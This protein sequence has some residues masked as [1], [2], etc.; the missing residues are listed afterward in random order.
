MRILFVGMPDSVHTARWIN[1]VSDLGWDLHLFSASPGIPNTELR[2]INV[3]NISFSRP[4]GLSSSARLRGLW[5]LRIGVERLSLRVSSSTWLTRLIRW[6][7]P[8]VVHSMEMQRAGYLTWEAKRQLK[9]RF[10]PWIVSNWGSDIYLFGRLAAHSE[11]IRAVM[12]ACDYYHCECHRDVQLARDFGFRGEVLPV[13]PVAGGFDLEWMR[14]LRQPGP[15]STRRTIALKGYQTWAGRALIGLRAIELCADALRNYR[16]VVYMPTPEVRIAAEL[17]RES[18]GIP[19]EFEFKSWTRADVLRLHGRARVS[20]GLSIS[21]AISTSLLEAMIMGSFPVQSN[22]A[23][24]DEWLKDGETG[25]LVPP[26]DPEIIAAAIRRALNDDKLVDR[27]SEINTR[28]ADE[29]LDYSIIQ[30]KTIELYQTIAKR[31]PVPS[32]VNWLNDNQAL[33]V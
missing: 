10:P 2:N 20:I 17:V 5:P 18:T 25:I 22:T 3:Y 29:R 27:A 24:A 28:V 1:Q 15:T 13:F 19:F 16:V 8:D 11:K 12:A 26:N 6:L 21:D 14:G 32:S 7:K 4:P 30:P 33:D 23:C 31:G 9:D